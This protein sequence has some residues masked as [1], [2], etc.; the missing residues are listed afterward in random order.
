MCTFFKV[1]E[2]I[3]MSKIIC[4]NVQTVV[5]FS[6][7]CRASGKPED[8]KPVKSKFLIYSLKPCNTHEDHLGKQSNAI[9]KVVCWKS[10]GN[11]HSIA[12]V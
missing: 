12:K 11:A 9:L 6:F 7:L 5:N 2:D 1:N 4:N 10:K 3:N 8:T